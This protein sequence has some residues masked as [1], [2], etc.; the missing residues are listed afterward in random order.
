MKN[1]YTSPKGGRRACLCWDTETYSIDCCD[2][3][4]HAQGIGRITASEL[5]DTP[6]Q[7][8][9][10]LDCASGHHHNLHY[11]GTL[12]VG[13][14]YNMTIENGDTG[15]HTVVREQKQEGTHIVSVGDVFD[16]CEECNA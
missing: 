1:K 9:Y 14:T 6:W 7:G 10:I 5:F 12:E 4:L 3:S 11:H 15:C 2:G 13:K 8:Y 16:T